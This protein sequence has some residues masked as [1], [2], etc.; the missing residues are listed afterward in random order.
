MSGHDGPMAKYLISFP[1]A[2][3]VLAPED[4]E[5]V[6][7]SSHAAMREAKDAGGY[8]F[9]G[10]P[11]ESGPPGAVHADGQHT[12]DTPHPHGGP[13]SFHQSQQA[14]HHLWQI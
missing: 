4:F 13:V 10:G 9:G 7:E 3:M 1:S 5:A 2:T 8:V 14:T 11:G 12:H 6:V